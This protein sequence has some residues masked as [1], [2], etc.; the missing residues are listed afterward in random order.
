MEIYSFLDI[1]KKGRAMSPSLEKFVVEECADYDSALE[2]YVVVCH[3]DSLEQLKAWIVDNCKKI[4]N[5]ACR[6]IDSGKYAHALSIV[7]SACR[8]H[9]FTEQYVMDAGSI[10]GFL[11]RY[12]AKQEVLNGAEVQESVK[13]E[14]ADAAAVSTPDEVDTEEAQ[15]DEIVFRDDDEDFLS[16]LNLEAM[17]DTTDAYEVIEPQGDESDELVVPE[18]VSVLEALPEPE[19]ETEPETEPVVGEEPEPEPV[20]E[21]RP[22]PVGEPGPVVGIEPTMMVDNAGETCDGVHL[23]MADGSDIVLPYRDLLRVAGIIRSAAAELEQS[24]VPETDLL[25]ERD[26]DET[27]E[28]L[29][30]FSP[31]MFKRFVMY[32]VSSAETDLDFCRVTKMLDKF[33][34]FVDKCRA[35]ARE[36]G[37]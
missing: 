5:H 32:Y 2:D 1:A 17:T 33:C 21:P 20:E 6:N 23:P 10:Q 7:K 19:L 9:S 37:K 22:E 36:V 16:E 15:G 35:E 25:S 11:D 24:E 27:L 30:E 31:S 4:G 28:F 3:E 34:E 18:L 13:D 26:K 14:V 12:G 8:I 29:D